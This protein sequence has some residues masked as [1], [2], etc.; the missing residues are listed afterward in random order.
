MNG[1]A[2]VSARTGWLWAQPVILSVPA[3][4]SL[5]VGKAV[6]R[7]NDA[8]AR[9]LERAFVTPGDVAVRLEIGRDKVDT[10]LRAARPTPAVMLD[11]EDAARGTPEEVAHAVAV[12]LLD[13]AWQT[14][15][16]RLVRLAAG[17]TGSHQLEVIA[18]QLAG[19]G[20]SA[21]PHS[22]VLPKVTHP[23]YVRAAIGTLERFED[24]VGI[25]REHVGIHLLIENAAGMAAIN[26]L[27][28]AA[29]SRL[30]GM[31]FGALDYAA[32]IGLP[33][34]ADHAG[35]SASWARMQVANAAAAAGVPALDGMTTAFPPRP[36]TGKDL[37]D[38]LLT[39]IEV[40]YRDTLRA[41]SQGMSGKLVGHP[42]QL[43]AAL[44]AFDE[45]YSPQA[46]Q[47][48]RSVIAAYQANTKG[49][50]MTHEGQMIDQASVHHAR[51]MLERARAGG[52]VQA[53]MV[54]DER[55]S[56]AA[57]SAQ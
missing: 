13:S 52:F 4:D 34:P 14:G 47:R 39:A 45:T 9:L 26:E 48:W 43:L 46:Q 28:H 12:A 41:A 55:S 6:E 3:T 22:V 16:L 42:A 21:A 7:R 51:M 31:L 57:G 18:R 54:R 38:G 35:A 53:A 32:D 8:L 44:L 50:A 17:T 5:L 15:T 56:I 36:G 25:P 1:I 37:A 49:G 29:G 20:A 27:A 10:M 23:A 24:A 2:A 40:T 11:G 30:A 33:D 19:A